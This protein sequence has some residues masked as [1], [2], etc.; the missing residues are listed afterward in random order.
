M[1]YPVVGTGLPEF[2][3]ILFFFIKFMLVELIL[4]ACTK[5]DRPTLSSCRVW[6]WLRLGIFYYEVNQSIVYQQIELCGYS[7]C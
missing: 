4:A 3:C 7:V 5:C 2:G 1:G 6:Q